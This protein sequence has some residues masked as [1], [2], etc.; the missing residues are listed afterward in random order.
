MNEPVAP[1]VER[2]P[3]PK[4]ADE[5]ATLEGFLDFHRSTLLAKCEGLGEAALKQQSI[6]P[7]TLTL[8]GLVR[9]LAECERW[10]FRRVLAG[11]ELDD[12]FCTEE[13][14]DGDF[15][16][17]ADADAF[18]DLQTFHDEVAASK[19]TTARYDLDSIAVRKSRS[20]ADFNLRWIYLHM[21]EEYARHNGHADIIRE[22]IDGV[23]G[24]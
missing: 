17:I 8:L 19:E 6:E 22:Q 15:D 12:I 20:G 2:T 14:P 16:L 10:W 4:A 21:F 13:F 9:H 7:S 18:A 23:T 5:R 3:P 24:E 11:D 1:P